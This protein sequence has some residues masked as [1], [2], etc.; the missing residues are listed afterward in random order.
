MIGGD[1]RTITMSVNLPYGWTHAIWK[2]DLSQVSK[3]PARAYDGNGADTLRWLNLTVAPAIKK[4][5]SNGLIDLDEWI[6][7]YL[8]K[9]L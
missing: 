9:S 4:A 6:R 8:G 1:L 2:P 3:I 7:E 5:A